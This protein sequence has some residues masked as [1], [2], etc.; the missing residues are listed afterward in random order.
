M[1]I[2]EFKQSIEA[3]SPGS[4]ISREWLLEQFNGM[5]GADRDIAWLSI[6][7]AATA[8]G[9]SDTY[10]RSR[11][12]RWASFDQPEIR[13]W[14][15]NPAKLRSPWLFSEADCEAYRDRQVDEP[16]GPQV[17][18]DYVHDPNDMDAL[19]AHYRDKVTANL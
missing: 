14:K 4:Q 8:T 2:S 13:V 1:T 3:H 5:P 19:R 11:A 10:L 15:M 7:E 9:L 12:P 18:P 6:R 17:V 16:R